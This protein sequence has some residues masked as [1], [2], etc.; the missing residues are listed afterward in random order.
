MLSEAS[1]TALLT[2]CTRS[3]PPAALVSDSDA[4]TPPLGL[5]PAFCTGRL[6]FFGFSL[7]GVLIRVALRHSSLQPYL[8]H[9][10]A[11]VSIGTPHLGVALGNTRLFSV[12]TYTA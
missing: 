1:L 11:F 2:Y 9:L 6:S 3:P 5:L 7:G 8:P 12:G 4:L 10:H